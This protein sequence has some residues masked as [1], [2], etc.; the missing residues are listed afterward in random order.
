MLK[1]RAFFSFQWCALHMTGEDKLVGVAEIW[2]NSVGEGGGGRGP[3]SRSLPAA[4]EKHFANYQTRR[5]C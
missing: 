3:L 4:L 1:V 5:Q 2:K